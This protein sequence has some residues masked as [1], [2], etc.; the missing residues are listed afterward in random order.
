MQQTSIHNSLGNPI[1]RVA[2]S[3][4][5]GETSESAA[6]SYFAHDTMR[7]GKALSGD[8]ETCPTE[9]NE[10][11]NAGSISTA[12]EILAIN[13]SLTKLPSQSTS[14]PRSLSRNDSGGMLV[15]SFNHIWTENE[16]APPG[17]PA[18]PIS[19]REF[20][21]MSIKR[22]SQ[23]TLAAL[24]TYSYLGF[25]GLDMQKARDLQESMAQVPVHFIFEDVQAVLIL[26]SMR[27][28]PR[29]SI[30]LPEAPRYSK[31]D[32][33]DTEDDVVEEFDPVDRK[34]KRK[35]NAIEDVENRR[36]KRTSRV[37]RE[38]IDTTKLA[39]SRKRA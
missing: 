37:G 34:R 18:T 5:P 16:H 32:L 15:P 33:D 11:S 1:A 29:D 30:Y 24:P 23:S 39:E 26:R 4:Q 38:I 9:A 19:H 21:S 22:E 2:S 36:K 27:T 12:E 17:A 8:A 31:S 25:R 20:P 13:R 28:N 35:R 10:R 7:W 3:Q 14:P 6:G